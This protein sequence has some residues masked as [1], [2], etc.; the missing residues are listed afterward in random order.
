MKNL[1]LL[2]GTIVGS[3]VL[4]VGIAFFFSGGA[5]PAQQQVTPENFAEIEPDPAETVL[6]EAR[7]LKGSKEAPITIV[8][9]SDFQCPACKAV[10]PLITQ[11]AEQYPDDVRIVYRHFP[12]NRIHP[13]AQLA[14]LAA[15]AAADEGMFWEYHDKLFEQQTVWA[16]MSSVGEVED[17]FVMYAD[18]LGIDTGSFREK[19]ASQQIKDRVL[20]DVADTTTLGLSGTPTLFV[21]NRRV[22]APGQIPAIVQSL[23]EENSQE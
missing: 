20:Q 11:L 8:E 19:I 17:T 12:L 21:N 7:N 13:Y 3:L 22:P 14:A 10:T 15:E 4:V 1:P 5:G 18:E 23:I 6:G 2:V 9:F 16:K